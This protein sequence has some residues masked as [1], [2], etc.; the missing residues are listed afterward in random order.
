MTQKI[1]HYVATGLVPPADIV[2]DYHSGGRTLDFLP[3]AAAHVLDDKDQ[4][5]ACMAAMLAFN[6]PCSVRMLEIDSAGMFD[7]K[8]ETQATVFVTTELGGAGA[9]TTR[10]VGIARKGVRNLLRHA[11]ILPGDPPPLTPCISIFRTNA[12]QREWLVRAHTRSHR[13]NLTLGGRH[14]HGYGR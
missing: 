4:E 8:V 1:A 3:F 14:N 10:S 6:A 13:Q 7:A 12:V 5:A 9:A 11:G 2:L